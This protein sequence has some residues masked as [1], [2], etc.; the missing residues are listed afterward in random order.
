MQSSLDK[1]LV[2][3]NTSLINNKLA[4]IFYFDNKTG[5][6]EWLDDIED[7]C[8]S[9]KKEINWK[10]MKS[11]ITICSNLNNNS[12]NEPYNMNISLVDNLS[13]KSNIVPFLKSHLQKCI[14]RS[15]ITK[16]LE[17][18][19]LLIQI[20]FL[21]FIRRLS[22]IILED[23]ILHESFTKL[24][25]MIAAYPNWKP[26]KL[27]IDWLLGIVKL[28]AQVEYRDFIQKEHFNFKSNLITINELDKDYK[29][30]IY[31]LYFRVSYG[32]MKGDMKMLEYFSK[33]WLERLKENENKSIEINFLKSKVNLVDVN[34][35]NQLDINEIEISS[36]DFHCY[37]IILNYLT[38][39]TNIETEKI[40]KAIWYHSSRIT[41]KKLLYNS[42]PYNNEYEIIWLDIKDKF[43]VIQNK[44]KSKIYLQLK[45]NKF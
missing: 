22:I 42:D 31:S 41:N 36:I 19:K 16:S 29:G 24:T 6:A 20:D 43:R 30:L 8:V 40:K 18:A 44:I 27:D 2:K 23:C 34:S 37:P 39:Y 35:I 5:C 9:L 26:N 21:E 15:L 7:K 10:S 17:T 12:I 14:R 28:L 1:W 3:S 4:H 25:W 45:I 11:N 13:D 33:I 38:K 32:G